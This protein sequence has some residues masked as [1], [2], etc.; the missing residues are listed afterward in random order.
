M[1]DGN[2]AEGGIHDKRT[3]HAVPFLLHMEA[4]SAI[5][6]DCFFVGLH[7]GFGFASA[8]QKPDAASAENQKQPSDSPKASTFA[9]ACGIGNNLDGN[10]VAFTART[11][12]GQSPLCILCKNYT[13]CLWKKQYKLGK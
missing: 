4:V 12:H 8:N 7:F 13:N 1:N 6:T 3:A 9:G 10:T 5:L 11:N 2:T